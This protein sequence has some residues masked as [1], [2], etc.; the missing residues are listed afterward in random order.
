VGAAPREVRVDG[1]SLRLELLGLP[2]ED[3]ALVAQAAG[4]RLD[5]AG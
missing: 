1:R 5:G 4:L 3:R 2:P